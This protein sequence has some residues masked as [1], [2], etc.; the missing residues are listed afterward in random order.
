MK[1][2]KTNIFDNEQE[3]TIHIEEAFLRTLKV[4]AKDAEEAMDIAIKTYKAGKAPE[5]HLT[6]KQIQ[7]DEPESSNW[8]EFL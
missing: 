1:E 8:V 6:T 3:Y 7:V 4:H 5:S 2:K